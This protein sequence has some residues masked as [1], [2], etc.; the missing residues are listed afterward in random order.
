MNLYRS[1][2]TWNMMSFLIVISSC[3]GFLDIKPDSKMLVPNTVEDCEKLLNDYSTLNN[4]YP[5]YA[6]LASDD[7]YLTKNSWQAL[8]QIDERNVYT[9]R[10]ESLLLSTQWMN[11]YKVVYIANQIIQILEHKN[12]SAD[13]KSRQILGAAYFLRAFAHHQILDLFAMPYDKESAE[14]SE[15][16]PIRSTPDLQENSTRE[17]LANSYRFVIADY[18]KSVSLLLN[19]SQSKGKPNKASGYAGLARI[20]LEMGD[21]ENAFLNADSS[22]I[23]TADLID[24]NNLNS[25]DYFP[26]P[27][28]NNEVLFPAVSGFSMALMQG[29]ARIDSTLYASYG[30]SDQRKRIFFTPNYDDNDN[31]Y[32]FKGSYDNS[33]MGVFVGLTTSEMI[34]VR[35]ECAARMGNM[36]LARKDIDYLLNKRYDTGTYTANQMTDPETLL[37]YIIDERRKEL[38]FKGRRWSDLKRLNRESR[39]QTIVQRQLGD[40]IFTL[41]PRSLKYAILIPQ[42]V[43]DEGNVN[44]NKR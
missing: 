13:T 31:S 2:Y 12:T 6:V 43:I 16:I 18:K 33:M 9:W 27:K 32:F 15:G 34:L 7:I 38:V 44:Q 36:E 14:I 41:D 23:I 37:K 19:T 1:L 17:S 42:D 29:N 8:S 4:S 24:F 35:A 20:F 26:I 5:N 3:S 21:T 40:E 11:T 30:I 28:F 22:L 25:Y 10:D 39:F